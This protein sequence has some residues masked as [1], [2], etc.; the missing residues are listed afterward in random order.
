[1]G[2]LQVRILE[3]VAMPSSRGIFPTRGSNPGLL[4]C[5]Q[6]V[7]SEPLGREAQGEEL[8]GSI[9]DQGSWPSSTSRSSGKALLGLMC[10]QP[11]GRERKQVTD[12]FV[13]SPKRGQTH[14]LYGVRVEV[15]P[16]VRLEGW[17]RWSAHSSVGLCAGSMHNTLL[18]IPIPTFCSQIFR[19]GSWV[20]LSFCI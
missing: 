17:L 1:M 12:S 19:N 14:S 5:R 8:G 3:W 9:T 11:G 15:C 4:H 10:W 2:I 18:L 20:F 13:C 7:A 6:T 16:G